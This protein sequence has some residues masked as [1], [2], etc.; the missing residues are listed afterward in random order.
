MV[1]ARCRERKEAVRKGHVSSDFIKKKLQQRKRTGRNDRTLLQLGQQGGGQHYIDQNTSRRIVSKLKE[2][3]KQYHQPTLDVGQISDSYSVSVT[4]DSVENP[5]IIS[6]GLV[7]IIKRR[8]EGCSSREQ[9]ARAIYDWIEQNIQ[10]G[11]SR[12]GYSNSE[13]V[14]ERGKGICGEMVFVY[15]T[16]A[17]SVGLESAFVEVDVDYKGKRV[18]HA[19]GIVETERGN[20]LVDPAYHMYDVHHRDYKVLSDLDVL[21]RFNQWR[22]RDMQRKIF[23]IF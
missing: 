4:D 10:Y 11:K 13:E 21:V 2:Q 22:G 9:K 7:G 23:G 19:C 6:S 5:F 16:M 8:T 17:R 15:V 14:L 12:S 3:Y 20:I 1:L 18:A